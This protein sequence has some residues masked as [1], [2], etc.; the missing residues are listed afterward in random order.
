MLERAARSEVQALPSTGLG[1]GPFGPS[2]PGHGVGV[3]HGARQELVGDDHVDDVAPLAHGL[4]ELGMDPQPL[5]G[6]RARDLEEGR[7]LLVGP[8]Q[9]AD[10]A[11]EIGILGPV[12]GGRSARAHGDVLRLSW[13]GN[14]Q[15]PK[16][17][18]LPF[19]P[20]ALEGWR[21]DRHN[22]NEGQ[23]AEPRKMAGLPALLSWLPAVPSRVWS[24]LK[25]IKRR[26]FVMP[27]FRA[28][29]TTASQPGNHGSDFR[30]SEGQG[31]ATTKR[32]RGNVVVDRSE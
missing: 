10:P 32:R 14:N 31:L 3:A 4:G 19:H 12:Q 27:L 16:P 13:Q 20:P 7:Q 11:G 18:V 29:R 30:W 6:G 2:V 1:F 28:V 15:A 17:G 21:A 8:A 9:H 26:R 25:G 24:G 5:V 22:R 23:R